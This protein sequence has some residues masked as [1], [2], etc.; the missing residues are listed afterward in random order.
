M[1]TGP[2]QFGANNNATNNATLI[3][4][5]KILKGA[6]RQPSSAA[7]KEQTNGGT[8]GSNVPWAT[9]EP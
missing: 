4:L 1:A 8:A 3:N 9:L 5:I 6:E 2:E 7:G